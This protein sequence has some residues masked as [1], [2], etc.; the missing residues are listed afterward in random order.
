MDAAQHPYRVRRSTGQLFFE[1]VLDQND[2]S[3]QFRQIAWVKTL[4][5]PVAGCCAAQ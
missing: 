3:V 4:W 1:K 5:R 2:D